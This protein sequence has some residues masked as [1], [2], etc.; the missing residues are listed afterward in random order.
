MESKLHFKSTLEGEDPLLSKSNEEL[1][2]IVIKEKKKNAQIG[3]KIM[4]IDKAMLEMISEH[5]HK[6]K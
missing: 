2:Q 6:Y 5:E 1:I 4:H 3:K